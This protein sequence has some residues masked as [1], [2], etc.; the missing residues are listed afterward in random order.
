M[1]KQV[2]RREV[3]WAA[4]GKCAEYSFRRLEL[5]EIPLE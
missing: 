2:P 4:T 3:G 1:G 5:Q